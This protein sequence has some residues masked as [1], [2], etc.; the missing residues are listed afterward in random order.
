MKLWA[1]A[2]AHC[3]SLQAILGEP[4]VHLEKREHRPKTRELLAALVE[5]LAVAVQRRLS[6]EDL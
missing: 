5:V 6:S 1:E 3:I 4:V 2:M